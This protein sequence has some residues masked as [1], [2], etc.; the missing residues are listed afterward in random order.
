MN[1]ISV[2]DELPDKYEKI[3]VTDGDGICLHYKQSRWTFAG[4]E[5]DDLH[6][7]TGANG[8]AHKG[9]DLM[10]CGVVKDVTHWMYLPQ[11]EDRIPG[12]NYPKESDGL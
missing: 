8:C 5:G 10:N 12:K 11:L 6:C 1:W 4:S 9:R 3:L 7:N 2:K